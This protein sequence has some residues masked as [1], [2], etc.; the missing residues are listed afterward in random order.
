MF[1]ENATQIC[2]MNVQ[3]KS[4]RS[5]LSKRY[6]NLLKCQNVNKKFCFVSVTSRVPSIVAPAIDPNVSVQHVTAC[7]LQGNYIHTTSTCISPTSDSSKIGFCEVV[8]CLYTCVCV[9]WCVRVC[10]WVGQRENEGHEFAFFS[11]EGAWE[12]PANDQIR[13][14]PQTTAELIPSFPQRARKH[15]HCSHLKEN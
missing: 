2:Y 13:S 5:C 14:S 1:W 9:C 10:V 3:I 11:C 4:V 12:A 7:A 6:V 15:L 8:V